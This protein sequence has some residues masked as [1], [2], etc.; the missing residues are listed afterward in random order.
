MVQPDQDE[1]DLELLEL[2]EATALVADTIAD[3][4]LKPRLR[5]IVVELR[6]MARRGMRRRGKCA[7]AEDWSLRDIR[8][9]PA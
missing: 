6:D 9:L 4:V 8:G 5:E 2:A 7:A 1:A 3:A